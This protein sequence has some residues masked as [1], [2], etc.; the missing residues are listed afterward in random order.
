MAP[1]QR[2]LTTASAVFSATDST[3]ARAICASSRVLGSRPHRCGSRSRAV[4]R[5]S[6]CSARPMVRAS[7]VSDEPPST[8]QVAAA[9]KPARPAQLRRVPR[10]TSSALAATVPTQIV[11]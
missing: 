11:V 8:V 10:S 4:L 3:T 6:A 5:S 2:A 1:Q 9:A 7:R